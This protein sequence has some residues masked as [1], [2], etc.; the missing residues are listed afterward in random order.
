MVPGT[1][2]KTIECRDVDQLVAGA[3]SELPA[4][5]IKLGFVDVCRRNSDAKVQGYL[6]VRSAVG[7]LT[8]SDEG[9]HLLRVVRQPESLSPPATGTSVVPSFVSG[10][11]VLASHPLTPLPGAS[12][13]LD[14]LEFAAPE[15][16]PVMSLQP[17]VEM[18]VPEK[19]SM[20]EHP[21]RSGV[22]PDSF[23]P[24]AMRAAP[25]GRSRCPRPFPVPCP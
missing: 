22:W 24:S 2:G 9:F 20:D 6:T 1:D 5:D 10:R 15:G 17:V 21:D 7:K 4:H 14:A 18:E 25:I 11:L 12:T 3:R 13:Y 23:A 8:C 19:T 16:G